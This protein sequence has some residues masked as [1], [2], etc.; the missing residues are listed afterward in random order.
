ALVAL[1]IG[2][3]IKSAWKAPALDRLSSLEF[4]E[5]K[6][7]ES[8]C[9]DAPVRGYDSPELYREDDAARFRAVG[10]NRNLH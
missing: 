5:P 9:D 4:D 1:V 8:D 10:C 7:F 3:A 2:S 6:V